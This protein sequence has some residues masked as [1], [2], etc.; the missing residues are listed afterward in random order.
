MEHDFP[1]KLYRLDYYQ[2]D[3]KITSIHDYNTG[4]VYN[5][6]VYAESKF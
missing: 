2:N 3:R 5:I 6:D 4:L 1:K